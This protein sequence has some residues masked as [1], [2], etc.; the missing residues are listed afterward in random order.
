M[1][2]NKEFLKSGTFWVIKNKKPQLIFGTFEI[3][4]PDEW[5]AGE[6][7]FYDENNCYYLNW[8]NSP[9]ECIK[10]EIE[11]IKS[12]FKP[13]YIDILKSYAKQEEIDGMLKDLKYW[14]KLLN[15][16]E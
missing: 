5:C 10:H 2:K 13:D 11:S 7:R 14:K 8:F 16:F 9:I 3:E 12:S 6:T 15:E 4:G 1:N